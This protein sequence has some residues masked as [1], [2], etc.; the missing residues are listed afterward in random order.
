MVSNWLVRFYDEFGC[1]I[2]GGIYV[3]AILY[4]REAILK[5]YN[6]LSPENQE[7][8]MYVD[9]EALVTMYPLKD[10]IPDGP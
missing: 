7:T 10:Y 1:V 2:K 6:I 4:A 8:V 3:N 9:A 5:A